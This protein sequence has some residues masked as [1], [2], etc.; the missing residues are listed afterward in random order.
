MVGG[1]DRIAAGGAY[2]D[3]LV[4]HDGDSVAFALKVVGSNSL[5]DHVIATAMLTI[6]AA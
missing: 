4:S 6:G 5:G 3:A 2:I 1:C